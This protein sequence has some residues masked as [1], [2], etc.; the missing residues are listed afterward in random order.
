MSKKALSEQLVVSQKYLKKIKSVFITTYIEKRTQVINIHF[1]E[2]C[3]VNVSMSRNG[4]ITV[5]QS[6]HSTSS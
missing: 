6:P 2:L 4:N 1:S 3:K 5:P